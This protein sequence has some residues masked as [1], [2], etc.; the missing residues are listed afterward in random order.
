[1]VS[2]LFRYR[3]TKDRWSRLIKISWCT[4][5]VFHHSIGPDCFAQLWS[6]HKHFLRSYTILVMS[7]SVGSPK[8]ITVEK[9]CG[10]SCLNDWWLY[11]CCKRAFFFLIIWL[12]HMPLK[13]DVVIS[14]YIY[15]ICGEQSGIFLARGSSEGS[16]S[17][18][19]CPNG[20]DRFPLF[21]ILE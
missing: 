8:T 10:C 5:Q 21:R 15:Q 16:L 18:S 2:S 6:N 3:M 13:S 12:P 14:V 11:F 17:I 4:V 9:L 19:R 1:M 20:A 7:E